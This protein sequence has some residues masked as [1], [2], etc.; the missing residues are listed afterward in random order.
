MGSPAGR[1]L[2]LLGVAALVLGCGYRVF[3]GRDVFGAEVTQ[4]EVTLFENESVEPSFGVLVG[5][6]VVETFGMRGPLVPV[7]GEPATGADLVLRGVIRS[8]TVRPSAFSP[9]GLARENRVEVLLDTDVRRAGSGDVVWNDHI[10]V[11]EL[12]LA[13]PDAQVN[14]TNKEQALR[15][16]SGLLAER[17]YDGLFQRL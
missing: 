17:I 14:Q 4:I 3:D 12:F 10:V 2:L 1:P 7:W 9:S 6:A 16:L 5:D 8:V 13:S 11:N 15:R